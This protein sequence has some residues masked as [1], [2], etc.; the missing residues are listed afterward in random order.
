MTS[1]GKSSLGQSSQV[2][3]GVGPHVFPKIHN[4]IFSSMRMDYFAFNKH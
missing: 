3:A 4:L 1:A 2:A